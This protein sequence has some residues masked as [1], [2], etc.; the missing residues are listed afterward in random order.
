MLIFLIKN[1]LIGLQM[2][3]LE[4]NLYQTN[5]LSLLSQFML[6]Y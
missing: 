2:K 1:I 6:N 3:I 4:G 5:I